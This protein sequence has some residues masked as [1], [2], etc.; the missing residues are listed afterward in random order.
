MEI[1]DILNN[2]QLAKIIKRD[3][4]PVLP[5]KI[6]FAIGE[7]DRGLTALPSRITWKD[8]PFHTIEHVSFILSDRTLHDA[9]YTGNLLGWHGDKHPEY[10]FSCPPE[11]AWGA[12]KRLKID[13]ADVLMIVE[14]RLDE[15]DNPSDNQYYVTIYPH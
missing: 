13:F 4:G 12:L 9:V 14:T 8:R 7:F 1:T 3:F 15:A 6:T 11:S 2:A 5:K 10:R